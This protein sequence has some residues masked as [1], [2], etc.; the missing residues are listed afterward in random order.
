[1]KKINVALLGFGNLGQSVARILLEKKEEIE[2][3]YGTAVNVVAIT[4]KTRGNL[5]DAW[6]IDLERVLN[7]IQETG[8]FPKSQETMLQRNA[9]DVAEAVEYDVLI[10]MTPLEFATGHMATN[11]VMAALKRGKHVICANKGPLAWHYRELNALAEK[12]GCKLLFESA[13][14]DGTPIFSI[15]RENLS[16][17]R[18][19]EIKGILNSTT[20]YILQGIEKGKTLK[21]VVAD[22]KKKGI[23]ETNPKNDIEGNEAAAKMAALTN[24][25][26]GTDITPDDIEIAGIEDITKDRIDEAAARGNVIK[27]ICRA[28]EKNGQI[29][30]RVSPEE[31][32]KLNTYA[33]V[34][35]TSQA[36]SITTDLMGTMTIIEEAPEMEQAGYGVF[37]DLLTI[38]KSM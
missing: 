25:L 8:V 2:K 36:I 26:M 14:M 3:E 21:E 35:G 5:V 32:S 10:E 30:V 17:C 23:L 28:Y 34:T 29:H 24:V 6:G 27:L 33:T 37:A 11:H 4:T 13:V 31:I 38:I 16:M 20:N 18:V 12:N 15:V 19:T 22:G 7:N 1:M 9:L